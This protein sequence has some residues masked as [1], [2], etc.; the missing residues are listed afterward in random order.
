MPIHLTVGQRFSI[1]EI[2]RSPR[3]YSPSILEETGRHAGS[4]PVVG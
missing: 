3:K 4:G 1:A 2:F